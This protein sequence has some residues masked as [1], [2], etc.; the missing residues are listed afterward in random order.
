MNDNVY[1]YFK[2]IW[3]YFMYLF[4][5]CEVV[6]KKKRV[7]FWILLFIKIYF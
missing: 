5:I 6:K 3:G 4:I 2:K 7:W 1:F